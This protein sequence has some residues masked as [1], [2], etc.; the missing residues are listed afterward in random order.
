MEPSD[1]IEDVKYQIQGKEGLHFHP[2]LQRLVF[3]SEELE[4]ER[5]LY[6]YKIH[7]DSTLRLAFPETEHI[8]ENTIDLVVPRRGEPIYQNI[9]EII[10]K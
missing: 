3:A 7:K 8:Y 6:D 9:G 1:T 10:K 2:D 4:N 5:T